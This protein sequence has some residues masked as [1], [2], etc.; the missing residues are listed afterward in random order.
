MAPWPHGQLVEWRGDIMAKRP[1]APVSYGAAVI[2]EDDAP[3]MAPVVHPER[4]G[5]DASSVSGRGLRP[6]EAKADPSVLYLHPVGK[7]ALRLYA[8]ERGCK[9]HD[10]LIEAVEAWAEAHG[11]SGPFRV[12]SEA[13]SRRRRS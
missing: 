7:K 1:P 9:V 6:M 10:L 5:D 11:L 13:P 8:V 2:V 4:G 3:P 12:P